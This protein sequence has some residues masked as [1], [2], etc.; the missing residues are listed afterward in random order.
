M[1]RAKLNIARTTGPAVWF[2]LISVRLDNS[3]ADYPNGD[4]VQT[5]VP[6][7]PQTAWGDTTVQGLNT[8][9]DD[10]E[11]GMDNGQRYSNAPNAEERLSGRYKVTR[12]SRK[13]NAG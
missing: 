5:V 10:I 4:E 12:T 2:K 11:R 6:W 7:A 9:L 13:P 1:D 8:I 3:D